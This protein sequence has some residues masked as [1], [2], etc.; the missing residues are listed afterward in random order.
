MT[1]LPEPVGAADR[2]GD[3]AGA[4]VAPVPQPVGEFDGCSR[5]RRARRAQPGGRR[6]VRRKD[7]FGLALFQ[8]GS[9]RAAL[10]FDFDNRDGGTMR[11]A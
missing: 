9:G 11:P 1:A 3:G 10:F 5:V 8:L 4:G 6:R 7:Q 2:E